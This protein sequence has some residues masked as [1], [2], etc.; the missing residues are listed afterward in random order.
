[1]ATC[2]RGEGEKERRVGEGA[3]RMRQE[4]KCCQALESLARDFRACSV[5][6]RSLENPYSAE[7]VGGG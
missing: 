1:M 6:C 3:R 2:W 7:G 5:L 4:C